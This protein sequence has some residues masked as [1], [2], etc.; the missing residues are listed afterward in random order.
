MKQ[1]IPVVLGCLLAIWLPGLSSAVTVTVEPVADAV[2][3]SPAGGDPYAYANGKGQF[4]HA[5]VNGDTGANRTLRSVLRFD[6][7]AAVPSGATI[8]SATLRLSVL[9]H[10]GSLQLTRLIEAWSEGTVDPGLGEG[11][12]STATAGSVTWQHANHSTVLWTNAGASVA[13]SASATGT[14]A[15]LGPVSLTS[16]ALTAEAQAMLD[17]PASNHGWRLDNLD[18]GTPGNSIQ[19]ASRDHSDT[20]L[21][22]KLEIQYTMQPVPLLYYDFE[23]GS[24][25]TLQNRGTLG[26]TGTLIGSGGNE[27][28]VAG[29]VGGA[30]EF[31]GGNAPDGDGITTPFT[32][33]QLGF[34]SSTYTACAW[35]NSAKAAGDNMV[36]NQTNASSNILHLGIRNS[37]AHIG[38]WGN[39]LTGNQAIQ[40][41]QWYHVVWEYRD[42]YQRIFVNGNLDNGPTARGVLSNNSAVSIGRSGAASWSF[43]GRLDELAVFNRSLNLAQIR[44]LAA[45]GS[46]LALPADEI[47]NNPTYHTAPFGPGGTWNLYQLVGAAADRPRT[48]ANAEATAQAR[49]DPSGLTTVPGHLADVTQRQENFFLA[50]IANFQTFWIGLTD[51]EG[52][53]GSEAGTDSNNGWAW[54][55]GAS[56]TYQSW[57]TGEPNNAGTG[58][59]DAIELSGS[60]GLWNDHLNGLAPQDVG[61]PT[62]PYVIEWAVA[63]PVPV[64]GA[65]VMPA[66]FPTNFNARGPG[67]SAFG[68]RA[69]SNNGAVSN[70]VQAVAS[71]QSGLGTVVEGLRQ[72]IN[73]TDPESP[74]TTGIIPRDQTM[75]GNTAANDDAIVHVYRSLLVITQAGT[76][77]FGLRSDDGS[78]LRISGQPFTTVYGD[79]V[80]DI[81]SPDTVY[82]E[83][84]SGEFRAVI[85]LSAGQYEIEVLAFENAGGASHELY[86]APGARA[87]DID[88]LVWRAVGH[89]ASDSFLVP[90]IK[91]IDGVNW[92]TRVTAPGGTEVNS[93]ATASAEL[94]NDPAAVT[95]NL[96]VIN[97][98]DPQN[99]GN[100]AGFF[101][102][103]TPFPNGTGGD[104]NDFAV[105]AIG[106]L[107]IPAFGVYQFGFRGDDGGSL[108]IV[109]QTWRN[110]VYGVDA[111]SVISGDTLIHNANT[112]NSHTRATVELHPGTYTIRALYWERGG[113]ANFEVYGDLLNHNHFP[114]LLRGGGS[115]LVPDEAGLSLAWLEPIQVGVPV[116][117][118][119]AGT[120]HLSWNSM[121][122]AVYSIHWS[123]D[124]ETWTP[125]TVAIASQGATTMV[126]LPII[127]D[128]PKVFFRVQ[129]D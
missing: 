17:A 43:M 24:G 73:A 68:V 85:N 1:L 108:Q 54:T 45:G 4:L 95:A 106:V 25:T 52:Y 13:P 55:S 16:A 118:R 2:I 67:N 58:G 87:N 26:G 76:Y 20:A 129:E 126:T 61:A 36:F 79:G 23:E 84:T 59:E 81:R 19:M 98:S 99:A 96:E 35:V 28:W 113:G 74:G 75:V 18:E 44:H 112:G 110:L 121:P 37:R 122:N 39:D 40:T 50:R 89:R 11:I 77:T 33:T 86:A 71:V 103:D 42:G 124:L 88:T 72:T 6:V 27:R 48:W 46:P 78:G 21:R 92:S 101:G 49:P 70:I 100:P 32:A 114:D 65:Q 105:E 63:S 80:I 93:L 115:R 7:A 66:V 57:N 90:G 120:V 5:G 82:R 10:T 69:V 60:T 119:G 111:N 31:D 15:A 91:T 14:V 104:D 102:G 29:Q 12:G 8:T 56:Y 107:E 83:R 94:L 109:G 62:Q 30:L 128:E 51:N 117:N 41:G 53:G 116:V 38:H 125:V 97:L 3:Y 9:K 127:P 34:T 123:K 47:T 64:P 22:P